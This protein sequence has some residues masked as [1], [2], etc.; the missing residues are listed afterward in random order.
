MSSYKKLVLVETD[1]TILYAHLN[2]SLLVVPSFYKVQSIINLV[3]RV[4]ITCRIMYNNLKFQNL[5][6]NLPA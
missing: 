6:C 5:K 4:C 2:N 1:D 3:V